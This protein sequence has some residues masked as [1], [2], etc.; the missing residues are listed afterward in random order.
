LSRLGKATAQ[1]DELSSVAEAATQPPQPPE[2]FDFV[3][4]CV[5]LLLTRTDF[6]AVEFSCL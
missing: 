1:F 2:P 6:C 3:F 4:V 5:A